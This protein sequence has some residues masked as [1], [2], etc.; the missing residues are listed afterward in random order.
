MALGIY[1]W[2]LGSEEAWLSLPATNGDLYLLAVGS[3]FGTFVAKWADFKTFETVS[4]I[5]YSLMQPLKPI[6]VFI[7]SVLFLA[8]PLT[9]LK[10]IGAVF[11]VVSS[12]LA[13]LN[14]KRL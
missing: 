9:T 13:S 11:I 8:E 6:L 1:L 3:V 10:V 5:E 4:L 12:F 14:R 7:G 2:Q